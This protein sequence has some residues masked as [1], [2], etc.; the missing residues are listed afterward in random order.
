M[1]R[2]VSAAVPNFGRGFRQKLSDRCVLLCPNDISRIGSK[3]WSVDFADYLPLPTHLLD[4]FLNQ[5]IQGTVANPFMYIIDCF[6]LCQ[7][8]RKKRVI[9]NRYF[10]L[11]QKIYQ[12]K[13]T[14]PVKIRTHPS[15]E[16]HYIPYHLSS[17]VESKGKMVQ[18]RCSDH[19]QPHMLLVLQ[20]N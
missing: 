14:I 7:L 6:Y 3:S 11:Y 16:E 19:S 2:K 4:F 10:L 18:Q 17:L 13:T 5:T 9:R 15:F 20:M 8:F 1:N 12:K